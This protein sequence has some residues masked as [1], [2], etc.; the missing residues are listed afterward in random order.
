MT[1]PTEDLASHD[2]VD[3]ALLRARTFTNRLMAAIFI[4][5]MIVAIAFVSLRYSEAVR[6]G[7]RKAE[8]LADLL[9]EYVALRL[10]GIDGVLFRIAA[11][12]L[13]LGGPAGSDREWA[14][15]LRTVT[16]GVP[17]LSSIVILDAEG[18]VRHATLQ[19]IL[20]ISWAERRIFQELA[21]D[22]PNRIVVDPPMAMVVG[23]QVL[24]PFGRALNDPEG[25][26][27]GAAIA[28]LVPNQLRDFLGS[29]DLGSSGI[30]WV[31]LPSGEV[32]FND[33]AVDGLGETAGLTPIFA[34]DA[35][36]TRD[37]FAKGPIVPGGTG[38][39]TAYRKSDIAN[40]IVAVS[41]AD[42]NFLSSW[43]YE[44]VGTL[45]LIVLAGILLFLAARRLNAAALDI[46]AAVDAD[47]PS[48][49]RA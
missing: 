13:R 45:I 6:D 23:D 4:V 15:A 27:I 18:I 43:T 29:F 48:D 42:E 21:K 33:G 19:Q 40:L 2:P 31:L 35:P 46:V 11:D 12:N 20:G 28:T 1:P 30:A 17:G 9:S 3:A 7:G 10:R 37:G 16:A 38:Y 49:G 5:L 41:I 22:A 44:A 8:T 24:V 34:R 14:S 26:F 36:M 25:K 39:L 32:L 47:A